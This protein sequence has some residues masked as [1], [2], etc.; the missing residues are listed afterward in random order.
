MGSDTDWDYVEC[1]ADHTLAV[2]TNGF[3]Y[4]TGWNYYGQLGL[5]DNTDR[6]VFTQISGGWKHDGFNGLAQFSGGHQHSLSLYN[7]LNLKST[8]RNKTGQLAINTSGDATNRNEF[9]QIVQSVPDR[10]SDSW[11]FVVCGNEHTMAMRI[12]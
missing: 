11:E 8:G 1:G 4:S 6:N 3:L 9:G 2:K 7:D 10:G 5:A 12:L